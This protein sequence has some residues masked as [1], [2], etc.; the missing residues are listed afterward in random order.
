MGGG[1]QK[2]AND[3]ASVGKATKSKNPK[4]DAMKH[5][6]VATVGETLSFAF[7][8]KDYNTKLLFAVGIVGGIGNGLVSFRRIEKPPSNYR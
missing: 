5:G 3:D 2:S 1:G 6:R 7:D 4:T 8:T